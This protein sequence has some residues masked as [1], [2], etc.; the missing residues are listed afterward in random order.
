M[1]TKPILVERFEYLRNL[2]I[3]EMSEDGFVHIKPDY[4]GTGIA[5]GEDGR[6][7]LGIVLESL[8]A[9]TRMIFVITDRSHLIQL[10][11]ALDILLKEETGIEFR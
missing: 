4:C 3:I 7:G 5:Q 10:S 2:G 9:K 8:P 6:K 11:R 1:M